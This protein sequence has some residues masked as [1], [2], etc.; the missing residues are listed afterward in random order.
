MKRKKMVGIMN[1]T[2]CAVYRLPNGQLWVS[3]KLAEIRFPKPKRKV[4]V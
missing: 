2:G 3:K 1:G 4:A